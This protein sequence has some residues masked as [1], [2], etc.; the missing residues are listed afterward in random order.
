LVQGILF[1]AVQMVLNAIDEI[2][3]VVIKV[4]S[5]I[6]ANGAFGAP[7]HRFE[8]GRPDFSTRV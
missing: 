4:S 8:S 5:L 6:H 1:R 2:P 3:D 7:G